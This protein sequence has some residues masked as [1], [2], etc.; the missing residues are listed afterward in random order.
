DRRSVA[1]QGRD[2]GG[3]V[4]SGPD[5][6]CTAQLAVSA[7][8]AHRFLLPDSQEVYRLTLRMPAEWEPHEA[9]WLAWPHNRSDWPGKFAPI[10]WVFCEVVRKLARAER[11]RILV[12]DEDLEQDARSKLKKA[13]AALDAVEFFRCPTNRVWTRDYCPLFVKSP[14]GEVAITNWRFNGWAKYDDWKLDDAVPLFLSKRL[15]LRQWK[16]DLVLE[17]GSID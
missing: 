4:R 15:K 7:R 16:I 1:R 3:G 9:T 14:R 8:P 13:G 2:T 5:R 11:V 12:Q 10:A 17:G 6:G